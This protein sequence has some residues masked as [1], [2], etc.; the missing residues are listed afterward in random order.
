[1]NKKTVK[2]G[3]LPYL[4]LFLV[5]LG[6]LYFFNIAN[7]KINVINY[8][9]FN[10]LVG[11]NKISKIKITPNGNGSIY[12]ITGKANDYAE[13]ES[14]VLRLPLTDEIIAHVLEL[15]KTYGFELETVS[16]P[17]TSVLVLFLVNV[18]PTLS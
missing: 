14:F 18:L 2:K 10:A 7:Q 17:G 13:N 4:L 15:Q 1:M 8:K 12:Q 16:D 9:E 6:I 5:M 3:L 11:E